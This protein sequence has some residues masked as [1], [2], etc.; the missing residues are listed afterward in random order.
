MYQNSKISLAGNGKLTD[1]TVN[2]MQ[3]YFGLAIRQNQGDLYGK[4]KAIGAILWHCTDFKDESYQ[5]RY[6]PIGPES[7]CKWRQDQG[8]GVSKHKKNINLSQW[9]HSLLVPIFKD[10]RNDEL[11]EKCLHGKTQN[12][13]EALNHIMWTKFPKNI[14]YRI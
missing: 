6:C 8:N 13:N 4:K 10:L 3:S 11:L 5:H 14:F 7:W 12:C 2:T 9:I 1:K